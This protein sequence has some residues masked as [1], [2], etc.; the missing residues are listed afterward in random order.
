VSQENAEIVRR[1][2]EAS[3]RHENEAVFHLYDPEVEVHDAFYG[4]VYRG[5][6]GVREW[7]G[8]LV[9]TFDAM[10][11]AEVDEWID[12]GDDVIAALRWRVRGKRSG[13]PVEQRQWHVWTLR[14]GK[15][16]RLRIYASKDEALKAVAVSE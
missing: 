15:L 7:F 6:D 12:A 8:D 5:W 11:S 4:R 2:W 14:D 13:V 3:I 1:A 9:S 16:W 10:E